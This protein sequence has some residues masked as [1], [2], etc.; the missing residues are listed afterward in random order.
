[1]TTKEH[2]AM[3]K[4]FNRITELDKI[5]TETL[6]TLKDMNEAHGD[7]N[8][9]CSWDAC[10]NGI[11]RNN[12]IDSLEYRRAAAVYKRY[13]EAMAQKDLLNKFGAELAELGFWKK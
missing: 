10:M 2:A 11:A 6:N 13:V 12:S 4:F 8:R 9:W 1:M 5:E 7:G 3:Q